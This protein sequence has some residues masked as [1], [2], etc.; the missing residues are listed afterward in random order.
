MRACFLKH[1]APKWGE[2]QRMSQQCMVWC[3]SSSLVNGSYWGLSS[4]YL[5]HTS[6][7]QQCRWCGGDIRF[8]VTKYCKG[9]RGVELLRL[10]N[11]HDS[12]IKGIFHRG[13]REREREI[14]FITSGQLA[15][16][17]LCQL[18]IFF[19]MWFPSLMSGLGRRF[20]QW[21]ISLHSLSWF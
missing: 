8:S 1:R 20:G 6:S 2:D 4:S 14:F 16:W 5:L 15:W 21:W 19:L 12:G 3:T 18:N 10:A 9:S 7:R 11:Q 17:D 13:E